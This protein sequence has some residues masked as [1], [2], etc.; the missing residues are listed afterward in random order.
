MASRFSISDRLHNMI[1]GPAGTATAH[2]IY[3]SEDGILIA[4]GTSVPSSEAGYAPGCL[5]LDVSGAKL[6]VNNGSVTSCTF[7]DAQADE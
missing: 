2:V 7:A 6:Y 4:Y 1:P 3:K 5:F